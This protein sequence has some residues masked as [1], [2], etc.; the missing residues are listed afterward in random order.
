M[1]GSLSLGMDAG[2]GGFGRLGTCHRISRILHIRECETLCHQPRCFR[3]RGLLCG[4]LPIIFGP[5]YRDRICRKRI[6]W[7]GHFRHGPCLLRGSV[8]SFRRGLVSFLISWQLTDY[9]L[10]FFLTQQYYFCPPLLSCSL[11]S[12]QNCSPWAKALRLFYSR[13]CARRM[14]LLVAISQ[15]RA[16]DCTT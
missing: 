5:T 13:P 15:G 4:L 16:V 7:L 8:R 14:Q 9:R 12:S 2:S 3:H 6:H 1:D 11:F 10:S